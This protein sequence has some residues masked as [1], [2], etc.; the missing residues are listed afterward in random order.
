MNM[1]VPSPIATNIGQPLQAQ[2]PMTA[3]Q[4]AAQFQQP[5]GG[6][7]PANSLVAGPGQAPGPSWTDIL[8]AQAVAEGRL[9]AHDLAQVGLQEAAGGANSLG[10]ALA[11]SAAAFANSHFRKKAGTKLG[12]AM[13]QE[14]DK[15]R[16][17]AL[18]DELRQ[19]RRSDAIAAQERQRAA[20]EAARKRAEKLQDDTTAH[21]RA[22]ELQD[23]RN[24]RGPDTVYGNGR[25]ERVGT[26][27]L[28]F[29]RETGEMRPAPGSPLAEERAQAA[30]K[31]EMREESQ[32]WSTD[33][34]IDEIDHA[35][36]LNESEDT[37]GVIG[38]LQSF[39]PGSVRK[40]LDAAIQ[41][42]LGNVGFDRLQRMREESPTGGA[43]G[44]VSN[45]ELG[46]LTSTVAGYDPDMS[47]ENKARFLR[48]VRNHYDRFMRALDGQESAMYEPGSLRAKAMRAIEAGRD[49]EAVMAR[50]QELEAAEFDE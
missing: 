34:V 44:Q 36:K 13:A 24:Q 10:E 18:E 22:L 11:L 45:L 6:P 23:R 39:V 15:E 28:V 48:K 46:L 32:R 9:S 33:N 19:H 47:P 42:V 37:H 4:A 16:T 27:G 17:Q 30:E 1:P 8:G 14:R 21:D 3:Q 25:F 5:Q 40:D 31:E 38:K 20:A 7:P 26:S 50:L 49:P 12:E 35:L 29:D 41:T 43:L 2:P